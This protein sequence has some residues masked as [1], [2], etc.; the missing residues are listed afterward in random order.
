MLVTRNSSLQ[1]PPEAFHEPDSLAT[2]PL[3]QAGKVRDLFPRSRL[4]I[5][6]ARHQPRLYYKCTRPDYSLTKLLPGLDNIALPIAVPI[7]SGR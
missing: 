2:L 3:L 5:S 4:L 1:L 7:Q 6:H